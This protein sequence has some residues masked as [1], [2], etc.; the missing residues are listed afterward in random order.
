MPI[1]RT[2][3][4]AGLV[5][6]PATRLLPIPSPE[7]GSG[8]N[9]AAIFSTRDLEAVP[10]KC[11]TL[12]KFG[13]G[14]SRQNIQQM[15]QF[16]RLFPGGQIRQTPSGE[17]EMAIFQTPSAESSI[18]PVAARF[19]LPWSAYVGLLAVKNGQARSFY[20][21]EALRAGWSVRQLDRQIQ[22]QFYERTALSRN[23]AAMLAKGARPQPGDAI[24]PEE[25]VKDPKGRI[26]TARDIFL[27]H[28]LQQTDCRAND[29]IRTRDL[30]VDVE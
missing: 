12:V 10:E 20:E 28:G 24:S 26:A 21:T 22:S 3:P 5:P 8:Q 15:R 11:R 27:D 13:R 9:R 30:P 18:A 4:C 23:K 1:D 25:E 29:G 19:P 16:Y 17:S 7:C 14:F 6:G 2:N